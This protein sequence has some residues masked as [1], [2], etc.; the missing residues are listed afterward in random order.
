MGTSR[1]MASDLLLVAMHA[2]A[3]TTEVDGAV[4]GDTTCSTG[5]SHGAARDWGGARH[6]MGH[7]IVGPVDST[8]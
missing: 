6:G 1:A 3:A 4:A 7:D 5:W 8:S 2:V